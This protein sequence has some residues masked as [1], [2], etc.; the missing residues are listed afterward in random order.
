MSKKKKEDNV[1]IA[2]GIGSFNELI[3]LISSSDAAP[4]HKE[5]FSAL[6]KMGSLLLQDIIA[7]EN[8]FKALVDSLAEYKNNANNNVKGK[9]VEELK[10]EA[11]ELI[12]RNTEIFVLHGQLVVLKDQ[13]NRIVSII[14]KHIKNLEK[15]YGEKK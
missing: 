9:D 11:Q 2:S 7:M 5:L 3:K 1:D 12:N 10:K 14:N 15:T 13:F 8:K 6:C 4:E